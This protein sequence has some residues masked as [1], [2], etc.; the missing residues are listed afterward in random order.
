MRGPATKWRLPRRHE[1]A[2]P[3]ATLAN[4]SR[5]RLK[6]SGRQERATDFLLPARR[7]SPANMSRDSGRARTN[8]PTEKFGRMQIVE[9]DAHRVI[10]DRMQFQDRHVALAGNGPALG[11][12]MALHLGAWAAHA[13][14]FRRQFEALAAVERHDQSLAILLQAQIGRPRTGRSARRGATHQ[15]SL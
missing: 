6:I 10:A 8:I 5:R 9:D 11:R 3:N 12:R 2:G 4:A 14:K 15:I 7:D 13:Q 1:D